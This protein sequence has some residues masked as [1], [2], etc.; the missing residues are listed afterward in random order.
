MIKI[1]LVGVGCVGKTAIGNL[2]A[3]ELNFKFYDLDQ[4]IEEHFGKPIEYIQEDF[5]TPRGY[6]HETR[7]VLEKMLSKEE[8]M[9]IASC[10]SGLRDAY[11]RV[12]KKARENKGSILISIHLVDKPENILE[13]I[14]FYDRDSKLIDKKLNN[15][16]KK[17]YMYSIKE[18]IA[19][20]NRFN[21]KADYRFNLEGLGFEQIPEKLGKFIRSKAK[22]YPE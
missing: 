21:R 20:F 5:L 2:L 4:R 10:P 15:K 11:W 3:Q 6:R 14:T 17:Y 9:V 7:V 16:E 8:D 1:Y 22:I 19:F 13:R 12:Y 18:D